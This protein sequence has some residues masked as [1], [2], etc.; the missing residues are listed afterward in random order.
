M[1]VL[2]IGSH[3]P[4]LGGVGVF[5]KRHKHELEA[6]GHEAD[7]LDPVRLT[8]ARLLR[9]LLLAPARR[10]DLILLNFP[11]LKIM[12]VL[13][14]LGLAGRTEVWDHN[15]PFLEGWGRAR[16]DFYRL[17]LRRS[18]GLV[19]VSPRL[20]DYYR[21]HGVE[22]PAATRVQAPFIPPPAADEGPILESYPPELRD[23]VAGRRPLIVANAFAI[24][25]HKGV[26]LYGLD[27][28][29]R[30]LAGLKE[31]Y[32]QAGLLFALADVGDADYFGRVTREIEA[33]GLRDDFRFL[34][35]QKELWPLFKRADLLVRPTLTDGSAVSVAEALHFGCPVVASDVADRPAGAVVFRSRDD[36]DFLRKC[37]EVLDARPRG[38][39]TGAAS[40]VKEFSSDEKR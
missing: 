40:G 15:W 36:E 14:L 38:R 37:R 11:S 28:C 6:G 39:P 30:L 32:P 18:R 12:A 27:M 23:F 3:P 13:L 17:F 21:E 22:L 24:V 35:G 20:K 4:P 34:T 10:Y 2:L 31:S 19:L 5:I 33:R 1:K 25:F 9:E 29:V 7:V 16:R 26:D 8:N